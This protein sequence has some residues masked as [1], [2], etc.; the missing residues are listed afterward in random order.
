MSE[1]SYEGWSDEIGSENVA[2]LI[3]DVQDQASRSCYVS[4]FIGKFSQLNYLGNEIMVPQIICIFGLY[5][6]IIIP[7]RYFLE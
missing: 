4:F 7:P 3:E 2:R 6:P 1:F 5:F